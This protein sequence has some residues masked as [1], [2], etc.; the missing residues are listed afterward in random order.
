[1]TGGAGARGPAERAPSAR[2]GP[3]RVPQPRRALFEE[4]LRSPGRPLD[5]SVRSVMEPRFG[6]DFSRVRIHADADAAAS[7][8]LLGVRAFA[9]GP[10]LVFGQGRF[11]PGSR[12]GRDLLAHELAHTVQQR[13]AG[14]AAPGDPAAREREADRAAGQLAAGQPVPALT[15]SGLGVA[16]QPHGEAPRSRELIDAQIMQLRMQLS[17]PVL[18]PQ[19]RALLLTRLHALEVAR[20]RA[21]AQAVTS[22]R[23][24]ARRAE[25]AAALER[26]INDHPAWGWGFG[27]GKGSPEGYAEME[28]NTSADDFTRTDLFRDWYYRGWAAIRD[29]PDPGKDLKTL[30]FNLITDP[31]QRHAFLVSVGMAEGTAQPAR[32]PRALLGPLALIGLSAVEKQAEVD[33]IRA[34]QQRQQLDPE[35]HNR[36]TETLTQLVADLEKHRT[37]E[38]ATL[39]SSPPVTLETYQSKPGIQPGSGR[40]G[41]YGGV[42]V[43]YMLRERGVTFESG[44]DRTDFV[45]FVHQGREISAT[46]AQNVVNA[47]ERVDVT[48]LEPSVGDADRFVVWPEVWHLKNGD[49]LIKEMWWV[50]RADLDKAG[51]YRLMQVLQHRNRLVPVG[52]D[53]GG[54]GQMGR[55]GAR[56]S[57]RPRIAGVRS[58]WKR[59]GG[60]VTR[61]VGPSPRLVQPPEAPGQAPKRQAYVEGEL[62]EIKSQ[63]QVVHRRGSAG[64]TAAEPP[65]QQR[66]TRPD[67]AAREQQ[68]RQ[69]VAEEFERAQGGTAKEPGLRRDDPRWS[70]R[71]ERLEENV[72]GGRLTEAYLRRTL[73][74][75]L[76][77][78]FTDVADQVR[79]QP[80][81]PDGKPADF[82]F[83][84]DHLARSPGTGGHVALD[85]KLSPTSTLTHNQTIGYPMLRQYGGTVISR[86]QPQYPY[87][88]RLAP[89][90][91]LRAEPKV[92]LKTTPRPPGTEIEFKFDPIE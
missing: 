9:L 33:A 64:R 56:A 84:A 37:V 10:H 86:N 20:A 69:E 11:D 75:E 78:R 52:G 88:T 15:P 44:S 29:R 34:W 71:V 89:S 73:D 74:K 1:M 59:G 79:I 54:M 45:R 30:A 55:G 60:P 76:R 57:L 82:H 36:L 58:V 80:N 25:R 46:E 2:P 24:A 12:A 47:S 85:A 43:D 13:G 53:D 8:D 91:T 63:P 14:S 5:P 23:L 3:G 28:A 18:P 6:H 81:K 35:V 40:F 92:D 66:P 42:D 50:N 16:G 4:V 61:P 51:R 21:P 87:G 90:P 17:M 70:K 7:A 19:V 83:I 67:P 32:A 49:H 27:G 31:A 72:S 68:R 41:Q 77:D 39:A 38:E 65:S 26:H 62:H 48:L 22:K